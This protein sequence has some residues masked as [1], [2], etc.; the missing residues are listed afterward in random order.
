MIYNFQFRDHLEYI[1]DRDQLSIFVNVGL[2]HRVT[3]PGFHISI[4]QCAKSPTYD[5]YALF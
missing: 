1:I 4:S 5:I 2:S 3:L